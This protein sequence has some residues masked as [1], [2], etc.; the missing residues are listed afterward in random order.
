MIRMCLWMVLTSVAYLAAGAAEAADEVLL[1]PRQITFGPKHHFFGYIGQCRTTPWNLSGRYI[2]SLRTDFQ[3]HMP[4]PDEAAEV[5][6]LDTENDYE[7]IVVDRTCGWNFQQGTMFY[8][9]PHAPETQFFFNDRNP[10]TGK[11]FCVLYDVASRK[12][13]REYHYDDTPVGN[14]GVR[15]EGG[16]FL[17]INYARLARLR[18]VTGYPGAYDW[19]DGELHP[20]DDG[21]F[22]IDVA[23]GAK[24]LL[25]S[26][27]QLRDA[28][29]PT[30]P[31]VA[32]T[33]LFI[34][35]TLWNRPGD[36]IYFYARGNFNTD[37]E[38]N[39]P[40]TM[41]D[42]GSQ[43]TPLATFIGGHPDWGE[44]H[45]LIGATG[46]DRQIIYDCDERKVVR[47]LGDSSVFVKPSGDIALSF[48]GR[49]LVNGAER[50]GRN[51]YAFF[52]MQGG[53]VIHTTGRDQSGYTS[54]DLRI[55][56][57]P[58]WNRDGTAILFPSL[59]DD[60]QRTRQL[61]IVRLGKR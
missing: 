13:V 59:A 15:Q 34:N 12:R 20:A 39:V 38:I 44:G 19:T 6:L 56:G 40:F 33:A 16:A 4:R 7:E 22:K 37:T 42:D 21:I 49:W 36:L 35:H 52:P 51:A 43:L 3:D 18:L 57:S 10:A 24:T 17:G 54:G 27:A 46:K 8:W 2:L 45:Q 11:V 14:S 29:L 28:L 41:R 61:F 25:V 48:D 60:P 55:D 58:A 26:Y 47:V 30:Y 23:T 53:E 31:R 1:E 9:N 5:V 32:N 50:D